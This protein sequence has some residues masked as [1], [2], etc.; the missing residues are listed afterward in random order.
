MSVERSVL[1]KRLERRLDRLTRSCQHATQEL[2]FLLRDFTKYIERHIDNSPSDFSTSDRMSNMVLVSEI[3]IEDLFDLLSNY[4]HAS[5]NILKTCTQAHQPID[6]SDI[7]SLCNYDLTK[8]SV[9][10]CLDQPLDE[11]YSIEHLYSRTRLLYMLETSFGLQEAGLISQISYVKGICTTRG[12]ISPDIN[13]EYLRELEVECTK[14]AS[15]LATLNQLEVIQVQS[16]NKLVEKQNQLKH[17]NDLLE[18]SASLYQS[19]DLIECDESVRNDV[20]KHFED[21]VIHLL[22]TS[23][24]PPE[25]SEKLKTTE[26]RSET[27]LDILRSLK[28]RLVSSQDSIK[29]ESEQ[30]DKYIQQIRKQLLGLKETFD[31]PDSLISCDTPS[32]LEQLNPDRIRFS[33]RGL[34]STELTD[35]FVNTCKDINGLVEQLDRLELEA[36]ITFPHI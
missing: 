8:D 2:S 21:A 16:R 20:S 1:K 29:I 33:W 26:N 34:C 32:H 25:L 30:L 3:I 15:E 19:D 9:G 22:L 13:E 7:S 28:S 12:E 27:I 6:S 11:K 14:L 5:E 35:L 17:M 4:H 36:D 10:K 23:P 31:L 18:K 24:L